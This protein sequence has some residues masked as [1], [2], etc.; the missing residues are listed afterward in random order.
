MTRSELLEK[1]EQL[2]NVVKREEYG[3]P[4]DSFSVIAALWA[5][6]LYAVN[7][8][9]SVSQV[10]RA[11]DATPLFGHKSGRMSKTH[12]MAFMKMPKG[13]K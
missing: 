2:V 9:I 7:P 1:A 6:Y 4:E 12:W 8:G 5:N 10:L 13:D 11:I 3:A